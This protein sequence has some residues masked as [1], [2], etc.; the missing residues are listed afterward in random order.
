M[1]AF[2]NPVIAFSGFLGTVVFYVFTTYLKMTKNPLRFFVSL[3][4]IFYMG[5]TM[6]F[7]RFVYIWTLIVISAGIYAVLMSSSL[8]KWMSNE[9]V[10]VFS[11]VGYALFYLFFFLAIIQILSF[12]KMQS[13]ITSWAYTKK[14]TLKRRK[15]LILGLMILILIY[16]VHYSLLY[17]WVINKIL[18]MQG[19]ALGGNVDD[20]LSV[21]LLIRDFNPST[22]SA[23]VMI[24]VLYFFL[25]LRTKN[26]F[27]YIGHSQISAN[28]ILKDGTAFK[29]KQIIHTDIDKSYLV[30]DSSNV[31][32]LNKDLIPKD[33]IN[34]I[35]HN[36]FYSSLGKISELQDS[37]KLQIDMLNSEES[38]LVNSLLKSNKKFDI[39]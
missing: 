21:L 13:A 10:Y 8:Y 15:W 7:F 33:N 6:K 30:A 28:F 26:L 37:K 36:Y 23:S 35:S 5:S 32:E 16:L 18:S 4:E 31:F 20:P 9:I 12:K 25:L 1:E 24:T 14:S 27:R 29:N 38:S 34:F 22:I 19:N 17:G 2:Y 39:K 3:E 11:N